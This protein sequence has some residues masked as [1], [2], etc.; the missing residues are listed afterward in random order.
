MSSCQENTEKVE[1]HSKIVQLGFGTLLV[2]TYGSNDK[3]LKI[4]AVEKYGNKKAAHSSQEANSHRVDGK[5]F[6]KNRP[7]RK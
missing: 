1:S 4:P 2:L 7:I 3:D 6:L 5:P